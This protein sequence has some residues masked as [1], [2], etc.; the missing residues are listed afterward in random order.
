MTPELLPHIDEHDNL[1]AIHPKETI[2]QQ[3]LRHRVSL[4][5]PKTTDN[6]FILALRAKDKFPHPNVWVCAVGGKVQSHET[7][8]QAALREMQEEANIQSKLKLIIPLSPFESEKEKYIAQIFTTTAEIPLPL[9]PP[10]PS[11]IQYFQSFSLSEAKTLIT[12]HPEQFAPSFRIH[13]Q[14]FI[15]TYKS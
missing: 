3:N 14:R 10:P 5:I 6:K 2:K 7:Y 4:I 8:E 11:Q 15:E 9:L 1:I 12:H 13:F